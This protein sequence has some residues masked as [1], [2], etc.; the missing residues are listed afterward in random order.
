MHLSSGHMRARL[1]SNLLK[2][3]VL[4]VLVLAFAILGSSVVYAQAGK[5]G[6]TYRTAVVA[7]GTITQTIG[8]AGNLAP[9]SEAD[10]NFASTGTVQSVA[11]EVGE[12][13]ISGEILASLDRTILAAQL[14]QAEATLGSAR[15]KLAQDQAGPTAQSLAAAKN[16]VNAAQVAVN[17]AT[18]SLADTKTINA[19][20]VAAAQSLV[21]QDTAKLAADDPLDTVTVAAD[22]AKLAADQQAL[23]SA[24]AKAQQSNNQSAAQLAS[25]QQQLAAA[26]SSLAALLAGGTSAQTIQIDTAQIQ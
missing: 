18:T 17:N 26:K 4:V 2:R 14:S 1:V 12:T 24:K 20:V 9:V 6:T 3:R 8:M 7:Y 16:P 15:S 13:V 22:Q 10:L 5:T 19:Q 23:A 11:V 21:D 25:A